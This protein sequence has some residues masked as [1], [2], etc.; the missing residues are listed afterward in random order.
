MFSNDAI[1]SA[2]KPHLLRLSRLSADLEAVRR[3]SEAGYASLRPW[4]ATHNHVRMMLQ[5]ITVCRAGKLN[6]HE[7]VVSPSS[8]F[9]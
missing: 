9:D 8:Q 6:E 4:T 5:I 1:T 7:P 3:K 2:K